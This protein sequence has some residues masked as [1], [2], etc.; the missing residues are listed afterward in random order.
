VRAGFVLVAAETKTQRF[1]RA[2]KFEI[3]VESRAGRAFVVSPGRNK[4][5]FRQAAFSTPLSEN[6]S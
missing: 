2:I 1:V 6:M 5:S 3:A 4:K